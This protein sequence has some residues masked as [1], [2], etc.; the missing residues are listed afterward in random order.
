M[1]E[2]VERRRES[3]RTQARC[4][5]L[6]L[7]LLAVSPGAFA[8]A[9]F[10]DYEAVARSFQLRWR[11]PDGC[12]AETA[13][14]AKID[15]LL[16]TSTR[17]SALLVLVEADVQLD[18]GGFAARV[19]YELSGTGYTRELR[20]ES[21]EAVASATALIIA[22][23]IDPEAVARA[24]AAFAEEAAA[25]SEPAPAVDETPTDVEPSPVPPRTAASHP[26]PGVRYAR[27]KV[28]ID[29]SLGALS[30][31]GVG[32]LPELAWGIGLSATVRRASLSL[33]GDF[34]YW[35]RQ[36]RIVDE[37][38]GAG[39][40]FER[41]GGGLRGCYRALS[42]RFSA[43]ACGGLE[44]FVVR[45]EGS[46]V[47]QSRIGTPGWLAPVLG[48]GAELTLHRH[49]QLLARLEASLPFATHH[50]E[51]QGLGRVWDLPPI[52]GRA[53]LG[54]AVAF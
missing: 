43:D 23:L 20:G 28:P 44:L 26:S 19:A 54:A 51:I 52:A 12:P 9:T 45:G 29:A 49:A 34:Q 35:G 37:A 50:F 14:A 30:W 2:N 5:L 13:V 8:Q 36:R 53:G 3:V 1:I 24:Q 25:A 41:Y 22:T 17:S 27:R 11:A 15:R 46:E 32:V 10:P 39:A 31:G 18:A 16:A 7:A 6:L 42:G 48:L 21:C 47:T 4:G 40:T 33:S 38:S